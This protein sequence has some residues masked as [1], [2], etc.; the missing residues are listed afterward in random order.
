MDSFDVS[1]DDIDFTE[2]FDFV[3]LP[4]TDQ[5]EE[6]D[7]RPPT[8]EP[9]DSL[10]RSVQEDI[11]EWQRITCERVRKEWKGVLVPPRMVQYRVGDSV[12]RR[13]KQIAHE[14]GMYVD[15]VP[16][17]CVHPL[18]RFLYWH[19][20]DFDKTDLSILHST[21]KKRSREQSLYECIRSRGLHALGSIRT[22]LASK[23]PELPL[24]ANID[25]VNR[26]RHVDRVIDILSCNLVRDEFYYLIF[27]PPF[28]QAD[29]FITWA[30]RQNL[31]ITCIHLSGGWDSVDYRHAFILRLSNEHRLVKIRAGKDNVWIVIFR[32]AALMTEHVPGP[33]SWLAC[34]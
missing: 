22:H 8:A 1:L 7:S 11:P 30:L 19:K 10:T 25:I 2:S 13:N 26:G 31:C 9:M 29:C 24:I 6:I 3:W 17:P 34:A 4:D 5:G 18:N 32:T 27:S 15:G 14:L 20:A 28:E 16:L 21:T 33:L 23:R 12:M